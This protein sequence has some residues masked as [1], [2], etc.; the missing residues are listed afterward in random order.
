MSSAQ[1]AATATVAYTRCPTPTA[2]GIAVRSGI[3]DADLGQAGGA[4]SSLADAPDPGVRNAHFDQRHNGLVRHGGN[5][6]VL[7]SRSRGA[8]VHVVATSWPRFFE[9]VFVRADS[10]IA[11]VADLRGRRISVPRRLNDPVDFWR[12][13]ALHGIARALAI[14]GL[15]LEDVELVDLPIERSFLDDRPTGDRGGHLFGAVTVLGHHR[16]EAAALLAGEVDAVFSHASLAAPFHAVTG[17]RVLVDVGTSERLDDRVNN[18][19][20]QVLTVTGDLLRSRPDLVVALLAS[21]RRAAAWA[22]V[23]SLRAR[24]LVADE[25]GLALSLVDVAYPGGVTDLLE[26]DLVPAS[27]DA[28]RNQASWLERHGF[29][30]GP[31]DIDELIDPGPLAAA[32]RVA[33]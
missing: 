21:V 18:G 26:I 12:P 22:R 28:L 25:T 32:L 19:V 33:V 17:A 9:P 7:V 27:Y 10:D 5:V 6:P 11:G 31:V 20:P 8:D 13:T 30:A 14:V 15:D 2:L 23:D 16:E 1:A 29:L 3:L 24:E 4:L